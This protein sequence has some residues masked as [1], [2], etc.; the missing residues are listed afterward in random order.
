MGNTVPLYQGVVVAADLFLFLVGSVSKTVSAS[1]SPTIRQCQKRS[2]VTGNICCCAPLCYTVVAEVI[3]LQ[4]SWCTVCLSECSPHISQGLGTSHT[5][6]SEPGKYNFCIGT[7]SPTILSSS[8]HS[9]QFMQ[10][11]SSSSVRWVGLTS[12]TKHSNNSLLFTAV[13]V[14]LSSQ[15]GMEEETVKTDSHVHAASPVMSTLQTEA[16]PT[17]WHI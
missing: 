14:P 15:G 5:D 10:S 1:F 2:L 16:T 6:S 8:Q 7:S 13:P 11:T 3:G 4:A 9:Q 17:S 12:Y